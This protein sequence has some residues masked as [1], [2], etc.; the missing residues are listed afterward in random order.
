MSSYLKVSPMK[1]VSNDS[2][3][4][5]QNLQNITRMYAFQNMPNKGQMKMHRP[6]QF[7]ET[8]AQR[9]KVQVKAEAEAIRL[10]QNKDDMFERYLKKPSTTSIGFLVLDRLNS[11]SQGRPNNNR[12]GKQ[13]ID[14]RTRGFVSRGE[15]VSKIHQDMI[16][17]GGGVV[18]D[19]DKSP[20]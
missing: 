13:K 6:Q 16:A 2:R 1:S 10:I 11:S 9:H 14:N 3:R 17:G 18:S 7:R 8:S 15:S 5:Y 20:M 19:V 12:G 4:P